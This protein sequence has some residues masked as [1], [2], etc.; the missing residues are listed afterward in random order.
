ME[1]IA[2][3]Q[4][5]RVYDT[6]LSD[7]QWAVLEPLLPPAKRAGPGRPRAIDL[8]RV[9][10]ALRYL[11]RTGCQWRLLPKEFPNWN[12]VRYYFDHWS[13]DGTLERLNDHL[14]ERVRRQAGRA[15]Q[16]SA[17]ILDTQSVK[18][19]EVGGER[20]FDGGKK[21]RRPQALHPG[22]HPRAATGSQRLRRGHP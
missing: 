18:T 9:V 13:Q 22:R 1:V 6:D 19:T 11:S 14:R 4:T 20:G 7:A 10:N 21:S 8:R 16:P 17:A 3:R 2:M 5:R 12:T 15:A